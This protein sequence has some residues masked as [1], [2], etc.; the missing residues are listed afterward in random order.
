MC[1][2]EPGIN[3]KKKITTSLINRKEYPVNR[4]IFAAK[5]GTE[6]REFQPN[7]LKQQNLKV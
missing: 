5:R 2:A 3:T 4:I 7:S 1:C 6:I